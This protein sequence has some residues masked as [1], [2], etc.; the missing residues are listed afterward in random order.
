M[1]YLFSLFN[2]WSRWQTIKKCDL[3]TKK[4]EDFCK[5]N[6]HIN[7]FANSKCNKVTISSG[8]NI[9]LYDLETKQQKFFLDITI[10]P[11]KVFPNGMLH[12]G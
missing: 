11:L 2:I 9:F 12:A 7:G 5:T 8:K 6:N 3:K 1:K 10:R 4:G